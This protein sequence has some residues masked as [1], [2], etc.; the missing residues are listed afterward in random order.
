M[1]DKLGLDYDEVVILK[2][3]GVA[4]GGVMAI[5]TDELILTNKKIIRLTR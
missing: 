5:Y 1:A 2:E 3:T 4:H